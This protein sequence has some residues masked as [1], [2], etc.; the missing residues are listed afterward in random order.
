MDFPKGFYFKLPHHNAPDFVKGS[1]NINRVEAIKWLKSIEGDWVTLDHKVSKDGKPYFQ[2]N[3]FKPSKKS[4]P[5]QS[6]DTDD[7]FVF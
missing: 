6:K 3:D 7:G 2:I 4:E 5:Q 1:T